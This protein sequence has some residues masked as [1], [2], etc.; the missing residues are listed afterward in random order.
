MDTLYTNIQ[1][2][3]GVGPKTAEN[4]KKLNIHTLMDML[5][6]FPRDY[7]DR[8]RIKKINQLI[9][10]E[11]VTVYGQVVASSR[12]IKSRRRMTIIQF[13]LKD[14][15]GRIFITF[16]N[17]AYLKN[18]FKAGMSLMVNGEV[19]RGLHGLEMVN[20]IYSTIEET[21]EEGVD[22]IMPIYPSTEGIKQNQLVKLQKHLLPF[23]MNLI[24]EFLPEIIRRENKLCDLAFALKGIHFPED[25]RQ[26]KIA[27]YRLI[28][29]EFFL[30]QLS[31]ASIK[32]NLSKNKNATPFMVEDGLNQLMTKLPFQLTEAQDRT[33]REILVDLKKTTPMNR[34]VQGD[35]GSGKTIVAIIALYLAVLNNCQGTMMAPTEILAQQHYE[36]LTELLGPLG[37]R[38]ALLVGSL[39]KG[40][41]DAVLQGLKSGEIDIVVG[42]H[43][44][45]QEN[46]EFKHLGLVITDE[47]H[48]FGVR[49]RATL[50]NKGIN[51]HILVMTATPIP[52]TLA[53]ILYGDL[54]ISII[55]QL[56][57]GRKEIKTYEAGENKEEKVYNFVKKQLKEGRQAYIVCPL[58]EESESIEAQSAVETAE[59]L[60]HSVFQD[61]SVALLHGK[62]KPQEKEAIMADFK[63]GNI[64]V[65]VSTTVIEV[66]V[67]VPNANIMLVV[68]AERFGLA[69]L[70]QLRGRVGR[71][72]HQSYCILINKGKN[73]I[74]RERMKTM[75]E[76]NDGFIISEKDLALRGPGEF[77]GTRQH[78]LPEL[79]IANIFKHVKILKTAEKQVAKLLKEDPKLTLEQYPQLKKK[80]QLQFEGFSVDGGM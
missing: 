6:H 23:G 21:Q 22:K 53:L 25:E 13:P 17:M 36:S 7:D 19:K 30:L 18:Q 29:D 10:G 27:K 54:D 26:L 74:A 28:F 75:V 40:K 56:P 46:V 80:L 66:G 11:K 41:K 31:L 62:M 63:A 50:A 38:I 45:I 44:V 35:V 64:Q 51:P 34:L 3:K 60:A 1:Y 73:P 71:G 69:Q 20:P 9:P 55:D 52:R 2:L 47:Q 15:T 33:L 16:F 57:P 4:L 79:K 42:T 58:V 48:R 39:T 59:V 76:T 49:Q 32:K 8:R 70:H 72:I 14:E 43:A 24:E 61:Y 77:F 68:N 78:G 5:Y 67:N 37:V 65:L 12:V